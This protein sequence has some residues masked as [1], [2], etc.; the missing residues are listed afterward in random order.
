MLLITSPI[1]LQLEVLKKKIK[2]FESIPKKMKI[3][4]APE[5]VLAIK[6]FKK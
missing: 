4:Q 3:V 6:I 5:K 1:N 2:I